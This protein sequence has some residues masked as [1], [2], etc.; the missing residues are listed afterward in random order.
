MYVLKRLLYSD[1]A[2]IGRDQMALELDIINIIFKKECLK[3]YY[4]Y[5]INIKEYKI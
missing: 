5:S 4:E 1:L 2:L 3:F